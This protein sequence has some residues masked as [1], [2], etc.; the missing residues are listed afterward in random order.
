MSEKE[1]K[2]RKK[3]LDN[4]AVELAIEKEEI[5]IEKE[6][7]EKTRGELREKDKKLVEKEA[8][9]E[10]KKAVLDMREDYL[11]A[12]KVIRE[13]TGK[14]EWIRNL[15]VAGLIVGVIAITIGTGFRILMENRITDKIAALDQKITALAGAEQASYRF[16]AESQKAGDKGEFIFDVEKMEG[17]VFTTGVS[18]GKN[19]Y[20]EAE[21]TVEVALTDVES[22]IV[23]E[24]TFEKVQPG[25]ILNFMI[26]RYEGPTIGRIE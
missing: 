24:K 5:E 2:K 23:L 21:D 19:L 10:E 14:V 26:K 3:E 16:V 1:L 7:V 8:E 4:R 20:V 25:D 18:G 11:G 12:A 6:K 22:G 17:K 15:V 9:L 13:V